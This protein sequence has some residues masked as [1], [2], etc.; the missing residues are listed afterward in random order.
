[1]YMYRVTRAQLRHDHSNQTATILRAASIHNDRAVRQ[2][3][4]N[5]IAHHRV[6]RTATTIYVE[7]QHLEWVQGQVLRQLEGYLLLLPPGSIDMS[8]EEACEES[9][10][11]SSGGK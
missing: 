1:M 5:S 3:L 9:E 6:V 7:G 11:R 4:L 8:I 10:N 2:I